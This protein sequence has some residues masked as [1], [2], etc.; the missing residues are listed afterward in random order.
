MCIV[1]V[2]CCELVIDSER[3]EQHKVYKESYNIQN[4]RNSDYKDAPFKTSIAVKISTGF[5]N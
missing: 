2:E 4:L 5:I 1:L 3:C